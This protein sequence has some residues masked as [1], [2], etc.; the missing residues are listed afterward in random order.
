MDHKVSGICFLVT[1]CLNTKL[2]LSIS[3]FS[4]NSI[5]IL[6]TIFILVRILS[7]VDIIDKATILNDLTQ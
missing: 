2:M 1:H 5:L 4:Q 3:V 7:Y 6:I